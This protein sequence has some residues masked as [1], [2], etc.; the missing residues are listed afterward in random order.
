M[1]ED[2]ALAALIVRRL[3]LIGC[4][5]EPEVTVTKHIIE[6][7]H[8]QGCASEQPEHRVAMWN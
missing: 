4:D 8:E 3:V 2:E 6:I 7:E 5:C 1:T